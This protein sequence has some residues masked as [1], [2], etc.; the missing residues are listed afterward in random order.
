MP[1]S[2]L[3]RSA[4][5]LF[6]CLSLAA[7]GDYPELS[8]TQCEIGDGEK[9]LCGSL[10]VP[11]NWN[12]PGE[13]TIALNVVVIPASEA[14]SQPPLVD[15]AGGPG[16]PATGGAAFYVTDGSAYR[17]DRNVIL[18]DQRGTGDSAPALCPSIGEA[19]TLTPMYPLDAVR[20]CVKTLSQ[21][22]DLSQYSS[23]SSVRDLEAVR[24]AVG[25]EQIDLFG[26]SYGTRLAQAYIRAYP[27]RVRSAVFIGTVAMDSRAPLPHAKNGES[28]LQAIFADCENDASCADA[29]PDLRR[30]WETLNRLLRQ[31]QVFMD[32][33]N[34][35]KPI[36]PGP[37]MEAFRTILTVESGQRKVPALIAAL[38]AGDAKP[39]LEMVA[40]DG[41]LQIAEGVYLS[42]ECTEGTNRIRHTEIDAATAN[43][44]LGRYRVDEQ[45]RAC[46]VWPAT[47][48]PES[49]FAP[50]TSDV[51]LLLVVGG[52]DHATP[53][54]HSASVA[55]HF[56]N[57]QLLVVEEMGHVPAGI[58]N[59]ECLDRIMVD[60]YAEPL[61]IPDTACV[62]DMRA[63]PF[64]VREVQASAD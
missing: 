34:E 41:P 43:T 18:F 50:V 60:F 54:A 32:V 25:A 19:G 59:L 30:Q 33:G 20:D 14:A 31:G 51:P 6:P 63:P 57:S 16:L 40:T 58:S 56:S 36:A 39:F 29:F 38:S 12:Q 2:L 11:E 42:I 48:V 28:V 9:A 46:S 52:R 49:F 17:R 5:L 45:M 8:L 47:S 62:E 22:H 37:F 3:T 61:E 21:T 27:R 64:E 1:H 35:R 23:L 26:M 4:A 53:A 44:F 7:C 55:E 13:R 24:A 10:P 15:L